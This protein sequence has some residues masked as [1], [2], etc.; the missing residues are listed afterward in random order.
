[1]NSLP[2]SKSNLI[3]RIY[4]HMQARS[5]SRGH[6]DLCFSLNDF[7]TWLKSTKFNILY[8]NWV[9]S[10]YRYMLVPSVDRK[11]NN[12][13][14]LFSNMQ[15]LTWRKHKNKEISPVNQYSMDGCFIKTWKKMRLA[16]EFY[17][18]T[19]ISKVC[20]GVHKYACGFQW[21]Y[22]CGE[23]KDIDSVNYSEFHI[24]K[25][26][27]SLS[28]LGDLSLHKSLN[29]ARISLGYDITFVRKRLKS[30]DNG[31]IHKGLTWW[32]IEDYIKYLKKNKMKIPE[33]IREH[34][35]ETK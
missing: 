13:G 35:K 2:V 30:V 14:Y 12:L 24:G 23:I 25:S 34:I 20:R 19:D 8:T 26:V 22:Y 16:E 31:V 15:I 29:K 4:H 6:G 21:R 17:S 27:V 28:L 18:T 33:E 1:M 10:G 5:V 11:D 32:Y 3:R 7:K 9:N